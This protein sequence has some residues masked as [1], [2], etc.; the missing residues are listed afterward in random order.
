MSDIKTYEV[1]YAGKSL[2]LTIG[3]MAKLADGAVKVEYGDTVVLVTAVVGDEPRDGI[4]FFPLMVDYEERLYAAGKISGSR[5]IKREGRPSDNAILNARLI[6]RPLRPLFPKGYRNDVQVIVTVLSVGENDP[7]MPAMLGASCALMLTPAPFQGP[8]AGIRVGRIDGQ[9]VVNPTLQQQETSDLDIVIASKRD[10]VMMLEAGMSQLP[11]AVVVDAIK[12]GQEAMAPLF[13]LQEQIAK[14]CRTEEKHDIALAENEIHAG[15]EGHLGEQIIEAVKEMDKL[16]REAKLK[17]H[18]ADVL[19]KFEG[20]YKK[21]ELKNAFSELVEKEVR[22]LIIN[23]HTRPDG[24]K[25]DEIRELTSEVAILP[26]THGSALFSRGQTQVLSIV[27]LAGPGEG[28][29]IEN[30][31]QEGEKRFMHHYNF[32]PFS[33]GEVKPM[34]SVGRR[35]IG[36][37]AL[38]ERAVIPV[39]PPIDKFPYTIRV[40]SEVLASNGS[41]SM[42]STCGTILALMDAGVPILAPVGGIAIGL[43]TEEGFDEDPTKGYQLLTDI[44]GIED[45]GGDMDFKVTGTTE[46]ITAIQLDMKVKGLPIAIIE[47]TFERAR[48][49]R[50]VVLENMSK[51]LAAPRAELSPFAPRI[52]AFQIPNDKIGDVIGPGGKIIR[53]LIE[54]AG[55][56]TV[57]SIDIDDATS[58]VSIASTDSAKAQIVADKI[59]AMV[60]DVEIGQIYEGEVI[61]IQKNRMTGAEIGAIVQVLPSKEGM[62]HI[63][64]I[65]SERIADVSSKVKVGDKVKV[66]VLSVDAERGRIALSIKQAM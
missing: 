9:F 50:M 58:T 19:K 4:E 64:E 35:E 22:N 18:E 13:D 51:A 39:I 14:E 42:A 15:I 28:Q 65:A 62:V 56:K 52:I 46:G 54:E 11:E 32:P 55:G 21:A 29:V 25:I 57:T 59:R 6:D 30:M 36:H 47:E 7:D 44:Q 16:N 37:G 31:E 40:V 33:V 38:A 34:R 45:F 12:F 27:T 43:I 26:R 23:E 20:D 61:G 63:S 66:K 60:A 3:Q 49:G 24:R 5:F 2:K 8:I 41:S 1:D 17:E 48:A 53:A 10:R